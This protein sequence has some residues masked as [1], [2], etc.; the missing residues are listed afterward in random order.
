MQG[1]E[2][3][4]GFFSVGAAFAK[5]VF[6]ERLAWMSPLELAFFDVTLTRNVYKTCKF[7]DEQ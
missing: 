4:H 3:V 6:L 5:Y 1:L 7:K 2:G